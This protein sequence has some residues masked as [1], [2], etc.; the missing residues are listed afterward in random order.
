MITAL[1]EPLG[2][3]ARVGPDAS[4]WEE[5]PTRPVA[6][7]RVVRVGS[8][9]VGDDT[10]L[11]AGARRT[12]SPSSW[13]RA[14]DARGGTR[15]DVATLIASVGASRPSAHPG[16]SSSAASSPIAA[17]RDYFPIEHAKICSGWSR[18]WVVPW[19]WFLS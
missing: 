16:V 6:E 11:V 13:S 18:H 10:V 15:Q 17:R 19:L 1:T 14:R 3:V 9:P 4:A 5:P 12:T 8:S 7:D 2:K